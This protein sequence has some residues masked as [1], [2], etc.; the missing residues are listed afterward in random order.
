[1]DSIDLKILNIIQNDGRLS[2]ANLA[3]Q[4]SM[5]P[6]GVLERV[7][8]L[9]KKGIIQ[10]YEVRLDGN[11][12]G[13]RITAFIHILTSDTV[14]ST[15]IGKELANIPEVQEVHWIAGDFNYLIK[16][17]LRTTEGLTSLL[18]KLGR[19]TGIRDTRTT[20]VLETLKET[21]TLATEQLTNHDNPD[22]GSSPG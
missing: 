10:G 3:R 16:G 4:L 21:Q 5:A 15:D 18:K 20:L 14:G 13:L 17:R 2:N 12:L 1:M 19:I 11:K 8:K 9:E 22:K 7:K 6:S